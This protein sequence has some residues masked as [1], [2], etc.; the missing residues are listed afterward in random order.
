MG[1]EQIDS[2]SSVLRVP[3]LVQR[4]ER[5][6]RATN[7]HEDQVV[8]IAVQEYLDQIEREK[9]HAETEAF[10][11]MYADLQNQYLGE[12]VAVHE[13][14]LVDHDQ[15]VLRLEQRVVERFGDIAILVAPVQLL[16]NVISNA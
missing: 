7:K 5:L 14:Q 15:D 9:I 1:I 3:E 13:Q 6:A 10:W 16:P 11:R 12:Y 8:E 4:V 2:K